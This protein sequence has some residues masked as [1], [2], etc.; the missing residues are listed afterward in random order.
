MQLNKIDFV[1]SIGTNKNLYNY[2]SETKGIFLPYL[3]YCNALYLGNILKGK[4]RRKRR[5]FKASE[6]PAG[7]VPEMMASKQL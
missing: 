4:P 6:M 3:D 7:T 5:I 1:R 2:L